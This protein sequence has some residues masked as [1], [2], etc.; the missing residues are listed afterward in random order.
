MTWTRT[1]DATLGD[2]WVDVNGRRLVA[3]R[4]PEAAARALRR[5]AAAG[6]KWQPT[7]GHPAEETP[8]DGVWIDTSA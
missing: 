8:F 3:P 2:V 1:L 5:L 6:L 4:D 7:D